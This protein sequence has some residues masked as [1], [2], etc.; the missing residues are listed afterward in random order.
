MKVLRLVLLLLVVSPGTALASG[1]T[2]AAHDV[3]PGVNR[4]V[5]RFDLVGLHWKGSGAVSFRTRTVAGR[6][7]GW[8]AAAPEDDGPDVRTHELRANGWQLG[9]PYWT[10]PSNRIQVRTFGRISR[11]RAYYVW[12]PVGKIR[13]RTVSKAGSPLIITRA[14]WR[15]DERIRRRKKPAYADAL[16]FAVVHHTAGSNSYSRA[17]SA[18]IVRGIERY[19]VLANGWDDIGYNFLVDKYGQVF[20]GRWGGVDRN[21]VG[22][23]AQGFNQGSAGVALIGT[24]DSASITPAA[25][26]A[27]V[28]LLAWRLDVAHVDPLSTFSWRS[29]G[30]PKYPAGRMITLRT[31]SGHRDTGYTSCPGSQLYGELPSIAR[32]VSQTGL[33]KMYSPAA[34]G[35]PGAP[36]HFTGRL[37]DS[38]PWSVTVTQPDGNI[39]GSGQG[40]GTTID[41]TWDARTIPAGK[42]L[43]AIDAGPTVRPAT[44]IVTGTTSRSMLTALLKPA[45]FTP[46]GDGKA[47]S[48]LVR[49]QVREPAIVTGTLVDAFGTP[50]TTLFVESKTKG[51]YAFR[52]DASGI[53]D[54]RYGIVLT[55]RN[56]IGIETTATL[57]VIVDRTTAGFQVS[58][59]VFSPNNDGRLDTTRFSFTLDKPARATLT[60]R[61]GKRAVG[62]VFSGQLQPGL[63]SIDWNGRFRRGVGEHEFRADLRVTSPV[64]TVTSSVAF[65]TD[66][67]GPKLKRVAITPLR[68]SI[69]EPADVTAVFDGTRS[70]TVRRLRPGK[71]TFPAGGPFTSFAA[72]AR[73]FAGNDSRPIRYP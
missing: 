57:A 8:R 31:I 18:S 23:H 62:Q 15:A 40:E 65:A 2:L 19:H 27:L 51:S 20:E 52:W 73:D 38:L 28:R 4:P 41:W 7:S 56:A 61:R 29:T 64:A 70:V 58:P 50:I 14:S 3:R 1:T 49:Y 67:T 68:F 69:D 42:Y 71:F 63:Q 45:L 33:P 24:Y 6:W 9:S 13:L 60:I 34:T 66:T 44:G 43:Y 21:V 25:R 12:S 37:T 32:A 59:Q 47:D 35:A 16:R 55:A 53:A 46:N 39:V 17:Q 5:H 10:G 30:N 26:A 11:V 48:T 54:G 36:V 72:V 22:A